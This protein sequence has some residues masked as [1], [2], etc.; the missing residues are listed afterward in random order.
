MR[1]FGKACMAWGSEGELIT[2]L[3]AEF[4][5]QKRAKFRKGPQKLRLRAFLAFSQKRRKA[6]KSA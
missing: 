2:A 6:Q 5:Q 4:R 3:S 1:A